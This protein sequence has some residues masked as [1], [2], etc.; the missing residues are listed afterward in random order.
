MIE[1]VAK[2]IDGQTYH[3]HQLGAKDGRH[4]L[5]R[6]TK[7]LGPSLGR[8][9]EISLPEKGERLPPGG[10]KSLG[11]AVAGALFELS[12]TITEADLDWICQ[13]FG[14]RTEVDLEGGKRILLDL[15]AQEL[16]FAGRFGTM[17]RWLG[18]CL[19]VNFRDFFDMSASAA[20]TAGLSTGSLERAAPGSKSPPE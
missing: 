9:A 20:R 13:T 1:T 15:E 19:E 6:L 18:A 17:I 3:L 2:E 10:R 5:V 14:G 4:M 8:L 12:A 16:H 11:E 7:V